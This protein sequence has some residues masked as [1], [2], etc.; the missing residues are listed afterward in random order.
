MAGKKFFGHGKVGIGRGCLAVAALKKRF[1]RRHK[2]DMVV[3]GQTLRG[4]GA[5]E[6]G[7][8]EGV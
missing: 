4:E 5:S 8:Q 2:E 6:E 3:D 7:P 1:C